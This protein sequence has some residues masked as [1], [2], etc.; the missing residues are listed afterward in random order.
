MMSEPLLVAPATPVPE[1]PVVVPLVDP[2]PLV[3]VPLAVPLAV[4]LVPL[5]L[6]V[7]EPLPVVLPP[8]AP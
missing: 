5:V 8:V 3:V 7:A 4:P 6:L 1:P 2:V